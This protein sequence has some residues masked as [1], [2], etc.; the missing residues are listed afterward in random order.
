ML[1]QAASAGML[2]PEAGGPGFSDILKGLSARRREW[3]PRPEERE[4][5]APTGGSRE[6]DSATAAEQAPRYHSDAA[7]KPPEE[8]SRPQEKRTSSESDSPRETPRADRGDDDPRDAGQTDRTGAPR[9][10]AEA[11][12]GEDR[13]TR[14]DRG[15]ESGRTENDG[16]R[17]AG[18]SR[19]V[20]LRGSKR[21]A[22]NA[23]AGERTDRDGDE[24]AQPTAGK[25]PAWSGRAASRRATRSSRP[26]IAAEASADAAGRQPKAGTPADGRGVRPEREAGPQPAPDH[27]PEQ[28]AGGRAI[29][30][31]E[32]PEGREAGDAH[33]TAAASQAEREAEGGTPRAERRDSAPRSPD[34]RSEPPGETRVR[35]EAGE[36]DRPAA[37]A[38]QD[39]TGGRPG[40]EGRRQIPLPATSGRRA[41][42]DKTQPATG[43]HAWERMMAAARERLPRHLR[44]EASRAMHW[45]R[46]RIVQAARYLQGRGRAELRLQLNPPELGRMKLEVE[47]REG[48]LEVRMRV[49]DP[50]VREV[51]RNELQTLDRALRDVNV[52]VSRFDV[53]DYGQSAARGGWGSQDGSGAGQGYAGRSAGIPETE[54]AADNGWVRITESGGMD[55]LV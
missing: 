34:S 38:R 43:A 4:D 11:E 18:K 45:A 2:A 10:R 20:H 23:A 7:E 52:D 28:A 55:C 17:A 32:R 37:E 8:A 54:A 24:A 53:S 31:V 48:R 40:R 12:G 42:G 6:R 47:M 3:A 25:E 1:P 33:E 39:S 14:R 19:D 22:R 15:A 46:S 21:A 27:D 36:A 16:R 41:G 26:Q 50:Q 30:R 9:R 49:E 29:P 44:T 35:I 51:I 5:A 13:S